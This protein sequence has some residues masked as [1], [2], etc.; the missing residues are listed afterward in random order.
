MALEVINVAN[1]AKHCGEMCPTT[2]I[3]LHWRDGAAC[4]ARW[5]AVFSARMPQVVARA[6]RRLWWLCKGD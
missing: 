2:W 4:G 1:V 3:A 6:D 5:A